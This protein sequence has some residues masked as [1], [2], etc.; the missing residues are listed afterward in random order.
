MFVF[1]LFSKKRTIHFCLFARVYC[2]KTINSFFYFNRTKPLDFGL[3]FSV[4]I[5]LFAVFG[6]VSNFKIESRL[7]LNNSLRIESSW[8]TTGLSSIA[9]DLK[10]AFAF[11]SFLRL[12]KNS[13]AFS[14]DVL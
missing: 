3:T 12:P 11:F 7:K 13:F 8:F 2:L 1:Q 10:S 14:K 5:D 4:L 9:F 6:K